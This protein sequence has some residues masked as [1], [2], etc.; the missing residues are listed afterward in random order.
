M[1]RVKVGFWICDVFVGFWLFLCGCVG[2][3]VLSWGLFFLGL[4]MFCKF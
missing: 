2:I 3:I 4:F 1:R